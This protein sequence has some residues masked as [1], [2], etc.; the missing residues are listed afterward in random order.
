MLLFAF[1]AFDKKPPKLISRAKPVAEQ[2]DSSQAAPPPATIDS[3]KE[4]K[5]LRAADN[6]EALTKAISSLAPREEEVRSKI[7]W[8]VASKAEQEKKVE[9]LTEQTTRGEANV[10]SFYQAVFH[11]LKKQRLNLR[12]K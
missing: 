11:C 1:W 10:R 7:E 8:L 4:C 9:L 12:L 3:V 6:T 2:F 5:R